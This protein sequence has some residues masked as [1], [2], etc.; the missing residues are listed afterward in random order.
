MKTKYRNAWLDRLVSGEVAQTKGQL[1]EY[2]RDDG[3]PDGFCC[4]GVLCDVLLD[5]DEVPVSLDPR[6][7]TNHWSGVPT[8]RTNMSFNDGETGL[9]P[10]NLAKFLGLDNNPDYSFR[11]SGPS[12]S[13]DDRGS[14]VDLALADLNDDGFTFAQIADVIRWAEPAE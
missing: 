14:W 4:L 2:G 13:I 1:G 12:N 6:I 8:E 7:T 5:F 10:S 9:L 11:T 3:E